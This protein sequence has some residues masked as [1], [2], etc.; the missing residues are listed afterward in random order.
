MWLNFARK[1]IIDLATNI[2]IIDII[3][4]DKLRGIIYPYAYMIIDTDINLSFNI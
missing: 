1:F 2:F 3:E 4:T